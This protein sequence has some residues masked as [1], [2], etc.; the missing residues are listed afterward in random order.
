MP[1]YES[2]EG[3]SNLYIDHGLVASPYVIRWKVQGKTKEM[4][5]AAT[6]LA[7]AIEER[8]AWFA[9]YPTKRGPRR[10]RQTVAEH[11]AANP[12]QA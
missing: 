11:L 10:R 3:V 1:R 6:T 8:D 9:R 5:L 2:V 4:L 12:E 7:E